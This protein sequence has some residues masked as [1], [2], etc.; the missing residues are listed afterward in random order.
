[1]KKYV[2]VLLSML[3]L[4]M[5]VFADEK[6]CPAKRAADKGFE[7]IEQFHKVLGPAWHKSW[8]NKDYDALLA[9]GPQFAEAFKALAELDLTFK[10]EKR[11]AAFTESRNKLKEVLDTYLMAC[12][13]GDKEKVYELMPELHDAFEMTASAMLPVHYPQFDG[14]VI[15]M[16]LIME[17][18]LPAN[19]TEGIVGSTETLVAKAAE[20]TEE[21]IPEDLADKKD[22]I[23]AELAT[24]RD[25]ATRLKECCDKN[26]METYKLHLDELS[27]RVNEFHTRYI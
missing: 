5:A 7:A 8:P 19:N 1:M 20:L 26:D 12:D 17:T 15:T 13:A 25:L 14:F 23:T 27:A 6:A 24:I 16:N 2:L 22:E 11:T 9:A 4:S 3:I 18:H 21:T 10:T